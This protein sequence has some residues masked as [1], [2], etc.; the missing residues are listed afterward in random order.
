MKA[1]SLFSFSFLLTATAQAAPTNEKPPAAPVADTVIK[2]KIANSTQPEKVGTTTH[3]TIKAD[4][5][6]VE[7]FRLKDLSGKEYSLTDFQGKVVVI[8]FWA[9]WCKPCLRELKFLKALKAK[10]PNKLEVLAVA[11][12]GPN[13]ASRIRPVSIQKRLTMPILLDADGSVMASMNARGILPQSN[14][15]DYEGKLAYAH[16]GFVAG[17]EEIITSTIEALLKEK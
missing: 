14:Y 5:P 9:T 10:H 7:N 4:R 6:S 1:I 2:A 16:D 3:L 12:D 8:S 15:L 13:T 11:T 17:D